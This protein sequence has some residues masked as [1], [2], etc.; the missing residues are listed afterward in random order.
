VRSAGGAIT[1]DM[2]IAKYVETRDLIEEKKKALDAELADLKVIQENRANWLKTQMDALGAESIKSVHGTCFIDWKDSATVADGE[3]YKEWVY[4][5]WENRKH[6][7]ENRVSK[8]AVKQ[9]LD[10]GRQLPPGVNYVKF[11]DVKIRRA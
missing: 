9:E 7:L 3:A 5:D 8:T 4:S 11:K 6:F 10:D 2:V 1:A